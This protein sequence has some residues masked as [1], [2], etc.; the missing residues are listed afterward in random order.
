[1]RRSHPCASAE[2][3]WYSAPL[4]ALGAWALADRAL[5]ARAAGAERD[6]GEAHAAALA[7]LARLDDQLIDGGVPEPAA[8]R[9]QVAAELTRLVDAPEPGAW[10][11]ARR[12]WERLGFPFHAAL[13]GWREAE[14]LLLAGERS[15]TRGGAA[16]RRRA[17]GRGAR[18]ASAGRRGRRRWRGVRGSR[19]ARPPRP[20]LRS[21]PAGLS[22]RELEVLR[23][24][25]E[26]HTNRE[27]GSVLFI[28]EKTV[29]VHVSRVLA[30]LGAANRAQAATIAH[31][32]GLA[33][34]LR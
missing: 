6:A 13:C 20:R 9:A 4:Y 14:A 17:A 15:R 7:L 2:Y 19:S 18:R 1:M 25:A 34:P 23:L 11:A 24:M 31:R 5:H 27:I 29:S 32:L 26:G 16:G 10:E 28:S 22:P 3:V 21:S 33:A 30:K 12:R 8:Y